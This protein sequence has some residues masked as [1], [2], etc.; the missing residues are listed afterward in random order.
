MYN[1]V[2]YYPRKH[3]ACPTGARFARSTYRAR[4]R[5]PVGSPLRPS[6]VGNTPGAHTATFGMGRTDGRTS[7][8][9]SLRSSVPVYLTERGGILIRRFQ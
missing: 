6:L 8:R 1:V 2:T 7:K 3:A 4:A 9:P 5:S